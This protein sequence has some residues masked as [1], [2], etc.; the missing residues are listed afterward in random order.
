MKKEVP[1]IIEIFRTDITDP[2]R[3]DICQLVLSRHFPLADI[4]FD[5]EDPDHILRVEDRDVDTTGII[6]V[7]ESMKIA[8]ELL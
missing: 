1:V 4:N 2:V 6:R 3:A 7:V 5:L 8:C